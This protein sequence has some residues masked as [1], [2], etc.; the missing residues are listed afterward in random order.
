MYSNREVYLRN[1]ILVTEI[2]FVI[3]IQQLITLLRNNIF[4][5]NLVSFQQFI[6]D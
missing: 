3:D 5:Q 2:Y 6:G 4:E 1:S